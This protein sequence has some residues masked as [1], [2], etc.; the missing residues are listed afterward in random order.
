MEEYSIGTLSRRSGVPVKV[1]R[2]YTDRGLLPP[3]WIAP[4]GYRYYSDQQLARLHQIVGLRWIGASLRQIEAVLA[5]HTSL[6]DVL[7]AQRMYIQA[8]QDRLRRLELRVAMAEHALQDGE[9]SVWA[10]LYQ[11]R[12]MMQVTVE[13]RRTWL[14]RWWR[15]QLAGQM[16]EDAIN[17]FVERATAMVSDQEPS[18]IA[19]SVWAA[20]R[21]GQLPRLEN[22]PGRPR[23]VGIQTEE[24]WSEWTA[25][26]RAAWQSLKHVWSSD[27]HDTAYQEAL[28]DWVRCH[29]PLT[30][31]TVQRLLDGFTPV[32]QT[33]DKMVMG[34]S[35]VHEGLS[36]LQEGLKILK[37][38]LP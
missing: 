28:Q 32:A 19:A 34:E 38:Q 35:A 16:S 14:D 22:L 11:L 30:Q 17:L 9:A 7:A 3:A 26:F 36:Q 20:I 5:G 24:S 4:S 6:S 27:P 15:S 8:E 18:E 29:G 1:I 12:E 23:D 21:D 33:F 10:Q 25:R 2:F 13:E 31:D 37:N